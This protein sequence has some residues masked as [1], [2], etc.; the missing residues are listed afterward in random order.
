M[1]KHKICAV[2]DDSIAYELGI[3]P[4]DFLLNI[5][6]QPIVDVFDYRFLIAAEY[7]DITVQSSDGSIFVLEIEKDEDED[8]GLIFSSDLMDKVKSCQNK[9]LFCFIDQLPPNMRSTVYFKD[10]DWRLSYLYGNYITLTNMTDSDYLRLAQHK[11]SPINVSVHAT[12]PQVRKQILNHKNAHLILEHIQKILDLGIQINA[13]IVLCPGINDGQ[14]LD[15]TIRDL[16]RFIP[17][18]LSLSVVPVGISKFRD[19]LPNL[20][21]FDQSSAQAVIETIHKW[22]KFY[23]LKMDTRF[24]FAA[25]EFYVLAK[26]PLPDYLDYEDFPVIDNGVG[27]LAKFRHELISCLNNLD[28]NPSHSDKVKYICPVG[29]IAYNFMLENVNL[30][31]DKF[32]NI[33]IEVCSITNNYFGDRVTVT[34]LLTAQDIEAELKSKDLTDV[35]ILIAD[36]MLKMDEDIFLDNITVD[37]LENNLDAKIQIMPHNDGAMWLNLLSL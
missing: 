9:C 5:N 28:G 32:P 33:E 27:M 23:Q 17:N 34:G 3:E 31:K 2:L 22:Q 30:I 10:D 6:G 13:Q 15:Q 8:L 24:V 4:G 20:D 18:I 35:I 36:N 11:L 37:E 29:V 19:G 12:D 14:I 16:S 1:K 25:D 21:S 7:L 26:L